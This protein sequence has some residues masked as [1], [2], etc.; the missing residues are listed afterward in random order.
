LNPVNNFDATHPFVFIGRKTGRTL[1]AYVQD[2]FQLFKNFTL[3]AGVRYDNYKLL[4][5][6]QSLSPRIGLTYYIPR[7]QTTLHASYNRLFQPPPAEKLL[8]AISPEA[9][10]ISPVSVLQGTA[11]IK[12]ILPDKENS[13]EVGLQ[14]L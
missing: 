6:E 9:A 7:T 10:A 14:Q 2:R 13:F 3:D 4:V 8:L 11:T 12:P 1:S 5:S